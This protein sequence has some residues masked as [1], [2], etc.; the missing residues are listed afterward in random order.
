MSTVRIQ[1]RR[2]TSSEWTSVNPVLAAG[3]MGVETNTNL[4]K[5]GNGSSTW[6]SLAYANN[7]DVAIGEISQDAINTALTMGSGLSKTYNDGANTITINVDTDVVSTKAFATSEATSKAATAQAA[8]ITAAEGYTDEA[9]AQVS[10]DINNSLSGYLENSDRYSAGGVA[11][12]DSNVKIIKDQLELTGLTQNI[13]TSG[14]IES[15]HLTSNSGLITSLTAT[16]L[17]VTGTLTVSGNT[18]TVNSTTVSIE[19]PMI[20][21]GENNQSAILDLGFVAAYNDGTYQHTGLVRDASD[22]IWKLFSGVVSEPT[23]TVDFSSSTKAALSVGGFSADQAVIGDVTNSELQALVGIESSIQDQLDNKVETS[24]LVNPVFTNATLS[25]TLS[26]PNL[27]VLEANINTGAVSADKIASAAISNAKIQQDAI[28]TTN[29][30]ASAVTTPKINDLAVTTGKIDNLSV[31]NEKIALLAI[32]NANI[33]ATA[34]IEQSKVLNLTT[35]LGLK[36]TL[37]SPTFTGTV[38]LPSTTTIGNLSE[39]EIGYLDGITSNVQTQITA[40][41]TALSTHESDTTNIHGIADVADLATKSYADTAESDAITAAGTAADTKISTAVAALTKS[42]VGLGNVDNT[43]DANKPVST[44]TQT[45]LDAKASLAGAVFTG[46][47]EVDGNIVVDGDLT[48]NGTA[49]NASST[50]IVIE[51]NMVQLAHSNAAN[52]V[53]LGIVV[54]YNDGAAKHSGIVRDVSADKWKL[55]KGVTTEPTTTVDFTEGSFDALQIGALEATT[56]T[57]SSG[58]VF[59]DGTQVKAGVPSITTFATEISSNSTLATGE[60]DKFVPLSGAVEITLPSTGYSTGQSIDFYQ[61]SGTGAKFL[62]TNDVVGTPGLAFRT[63]NSVVTAMKT[64]TGWLVFG[65]LKA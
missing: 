54:G 51:D 3:E 35:A 30:L 21:L 2:G 65:D 49:F 34:D 55:F 28:S 64:S 57:P 18:T 41:G 58:I 52:T 27:S 62:S 43:S 17:D 36:A 9:V 6:T 26:L 7:S 8:A 5:F 1:V 15:D 56:V 61:A 20:Y 50:S 13:E 60:Q 4:F 45:A 12:L 38:V 25:G 23:T 47:V 63:T 48:V 24:V 32:T 42:S 40:A 29:I 39:T 46:N 14:D 19:D 37:D 10:T 53:D 31:T 22:G 16:D 59:S 11:G 44:A 33:S